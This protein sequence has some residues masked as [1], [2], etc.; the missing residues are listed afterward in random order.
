MLTTA[1]YF[2]QVVLCSGVMMGYYWLVLRNKRFHQYNRFYLLI[3]ALLS[4]VVP[5]VKI[6]WTRPVADTDQQVIQFLS[7]VADSNSQIDETLINNGFQWSWDAAATFL[8]VAVAGIL[9]LGM[10]RAFFR[11]YRLMQEHPCKTV[12][13]VYLILTQAKGT[14]F[15][16]FRYIFWNEAIDIRSE[17]GKQI[18]QHELTHVQQKHSVDK[19]LMQLVLIAGWFNPFFWLLKKEMNMIHEFIADKR[20]VNN[21]DTASLAQMLLTAAYPQQRFD[22]THP[23]FFSPIKRRL[24]MLT[25]NKN[26]RFSYIRRLI[27]LPL[28]A[29]VLVMF[30]FRSK[31][32][33]ANRTLSVATVMEN[34]QTQLNKAALGLDTL[35][36]KET[37]KEG[38]IQIS[39]PKNSG[40]EKALIIVDGKKAAKEVL[41]S[42]DPN[43]IQSVDILKNESA[44]AL[45][46]EEG[47]NGVIVIKTKWAGRNLAVKG[48]VEGGLFSGTLALSNVKAVVEG[49]IYSSTLVPANVKGFMTPPAFMGNNGVMIQFPDSVINFMDKNGKVVSN[50]PLVLVDGIKT[51]VGSIDQSNVQS[52]NVWKDKEAI[53]KYGEE[54][55]NGV[56]EITTKKTPGITGSL[57]VQEVQPREVT[58]QGFPTGRPTMVGYSTDPA[59][60]AFKKRNP[61]INNV[62]WKNAGE[63]IVIALYDGTEETYD[64]TNS[65]SKRRAENK[66]GKLPAAPPPPPSQPIVGKLANITSVGA[67]ASFTVTGTVQR[68]NAAT[69]NMTVTGYITHPNGSQVVPGEQVPAS[70]P[71]GPAAWSKYLERNQDKD[72]V[73]KNGGPPGK[74][75][76]VISFIVD[77]AGHLS[78]VTAENDPG[79]GSKEA[80]VRLINKGPMWR[81]ATLYGKPV[82]YRQRQAISFYVGDL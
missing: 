3:I 23:F 46:G 24:Q 73:K 51:K 65:G 78:E 30:A 38:N 18:L 74:Y 82:V 49:G 35:I 45:Y 22:M 32:Q 8:Y 14:P 71:G 33:R 44:T 25:N 29:I 9:L 15:S 5:L 68:A 21:G 77:K 7:V 53:D 62:S 28:L 48:V 75:T 13:D 43:Q 52:V 50:Q 61:S 17:A 69:P 59:I 19:I 79:Y 2:L 27:V 55:K 39:M 57:Q 76:V 63:K 1:Y 41:E 37:A 56:V 81:P 26:P 40:M 10:L 36:I 64:L 72:L 20:A 6:R 60:G 16:F 12:G 58:V 42:L 66:Y 34:V 54:G 67:M 4:W 70:F 31:E 47:K 80:A 11:L